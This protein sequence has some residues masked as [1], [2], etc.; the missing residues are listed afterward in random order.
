MSE[1]RSL[2]DF[3][4]ADDD[5]SDDVD[6]DADS[7]ADDDSSEP[8]SDDA[9]DGDGCDSRNEDAE[10][11]RTTLRWT[12][13]GDDCP[14]CGARVERQWRDGDRFVCADCKEW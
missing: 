9:P 14:A 2:D 7:H 5:G 11:P 12:P 13:A 8:R 10:R 3:L 1:N 4:P 6:G